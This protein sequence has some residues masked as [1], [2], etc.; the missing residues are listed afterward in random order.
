MFSACQWSR[1]KRTCTHV[2]VVYG[3]K[4]IEILQVMGKT[5][6]M[7]G[8]FEMGIP[9]TAPLPLVPRVGSPAIPQPVHM[10]SSG[11]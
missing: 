2:H 8:G 5:V 10:S 9:P 4:V 11:I 3:G 6:G 7:K 1:H